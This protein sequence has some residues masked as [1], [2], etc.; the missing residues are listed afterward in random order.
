MGLPNVYEMSF[1]D[2]LLPYRGAFSCLNKRNKLLFE[3]M[4]RRSNQQADLSALTDANP[5]YDLD[6]VYFSDHGWAYRHYKDETGALYWDEILVAGEALL[7]DGTPDTTA[8]AFGAANPTFLVGDGS[9]AERLT[10][11]PVWISGSTFNGTGDT[12]A[13]GTLRA[14]TLSINAE[15]YPDITAIDSIVWATTDGLAS[16]I[17]VIATDENNQTVNFTHGGTPG[18]FTLTATITDAAASD[19]P[20][21]ASFEYSTTTV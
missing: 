8:D 1:M 18:S 17:S 14:Y 15:D 9:Q 12:Y 5:V 13:T 19:S 16:A 4:P 7:D 11:R 21:V 10:I 3:A 20:V 2:K 6:N